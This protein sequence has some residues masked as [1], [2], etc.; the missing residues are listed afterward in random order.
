[1]IKRLAYLERQHRAFCQAKGI[2]VFGSLALLIDTYCVQT[3]WQE[4]T[5]EF[6]L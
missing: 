1:M 3:V 5:V 6:G 4:A 2:P